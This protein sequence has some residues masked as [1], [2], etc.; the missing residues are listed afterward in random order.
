MYVHPDR[1]ILNLKE[2]WP[3]KLSPFD[4]IPRLPQDKILTHLIDVAY[5]ASFLTEEKRK[6]GFR[7][8]Y[9][10]KQKIENIFQEF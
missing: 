8:M 9:C 3:K 2:T 1:L 10:S 6:I 7:L 4:N 5:H